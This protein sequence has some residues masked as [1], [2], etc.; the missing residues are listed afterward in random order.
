MEM[1]H[2]QE[3]LDLITANLTNEWD[4]LVFFAY[5]FENNYSMKF[6][7]KNLVGQYVSC[8]DLEGISDSEIIG[9]FESIDEIISNERKKL[10]DN[11]RWTGITMIVS[12]NGSVKT[13]FS[14][15]DHS[16]DYISYLEDI[17]NRYCR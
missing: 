17:E 8:Y 2:L 16:T 4:E 13:E 14:Y 9:I 11:M 1:E 7:Y 3:I 5:Y 12:P 10:D 6:C 15:D